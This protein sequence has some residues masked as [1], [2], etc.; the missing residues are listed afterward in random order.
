M[1][2]TIQVVLENIDKDDRFFNFFTFQKIKKNSKNV[3]K[4]FPLL[5]I[6]K[7]LEPINHNEYTLLFSYWLTFKKSLKE[8]GTKE[9]EECYNQISLKPSANTST[10]LNRLSNGKDAPLIT[11]KEGI[12]KL[13]ISG[14]DDVE[15]WI[16]KS[17]KEK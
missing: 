12:Y 8:F 1:N 14:I 17:I 6:F 7:L 9:I 3:V 10:Y 4:N 2:N 11:I 13:S 5:D 15:K 16:D